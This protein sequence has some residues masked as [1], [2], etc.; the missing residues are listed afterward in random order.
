[1]RSLN[2]DSEMI[3][4]GLL[5]SHSLRRTVLSIFCSNIFN[6]ERSQ[7]GEQSRQSALLGRAVN[8]VQQKRTVLWTE[9]KKS[10]F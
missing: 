10:D 5:C 4:K 9:N 7:E 8:Q 1:M 3:I 6:V 2:L